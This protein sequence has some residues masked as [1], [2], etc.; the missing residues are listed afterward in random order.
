M[1]VRVTNAQRAAIVAAANAVLSVSVLLGVPL[2]ADQAAGIGVAVNALLGVWVTFT[3][4]DS[5]KRIPD[6]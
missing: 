2:S 5:P 6:E 1:E 4:K 3:Y